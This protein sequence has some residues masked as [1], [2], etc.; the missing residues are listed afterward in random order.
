MAEKGLLVF[1]D[2]GSRGNPGPAAAACVIEDPIS[3]KKFL[4]GRYLG[5]A[6]NNQAEYA[7]VVL[8]LKIIKE[9]FQKKQKINFF[10]DSN[11]VVNQLSGFFKVKDARIRE[12]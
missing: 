4:A 12:T 2:G 7:A 8:A 3:K 10:L 1:C 5:T 6:T 11:L 9:K